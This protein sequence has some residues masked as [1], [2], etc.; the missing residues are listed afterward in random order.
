M[1]TTKITPTYINDTAYVAA[2]TQHANSIY[3]DAVAWTAIQIAIMIGKRLISSSINDMRE[4]LAKRRVVM[5]EEVLA[6]A[7]EFWPKEIV[8]LQRTMAEAKY[9]ADYS[10]IDTDKAFADSAMNDM[11]TE[12]DSVLENAGISST[13]CMDNRTHRLLALGRTDITSHAMRAA[14]ARA[15]TLNDR[16][17]S[18]QKAVL[19]MGRGVLQEAVTFGNL[20]GKARYAISDTLINTLNSAGSLW[21]YMQSRT[22]TESLGWATS[23]QDV[24]RVISTSARG[25]YSGTR[26]TSSVPTQDA[27]DQRLAFGNTPGAE[28][29]SANAVSG[30]G[31]VTGTPLP[32]ASTT[33]AGDN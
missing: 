24:P 13:Q 31:T 5:A 15:L 21:G 20:A 14:E 19:A 9:S 33:G 29:V 7:K 10:A 25:L 27:A 1:S 17:F 12:L 3:A 30:W 11:V 4:E 28:A 18:R 22:R 26:S 32:A 23:Y 6:H 2:A 8:F 16:R